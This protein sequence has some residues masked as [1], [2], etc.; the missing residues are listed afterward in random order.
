MVSIAEYFYLLLLQVKTNDGTGD[1]PVTSSY[2]QMSNGCIQGSYVDMPVRRNVTKIFVEL[3]RDGSYVGLSELEIFVEGKEI[4]E[5][6]VC[7]VLIKGVTEQKI[8][9]C[10]E[11]CRWCTVKLGYYVHR[12]V[13]K[14][15]LYYKRGDR[16][17]GAGSIVMTGLN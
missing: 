1:V 12:R 4:W 11:R 7:H 17:N 15:W 9:R 8:R 3:N 5:R 6:L 16:I 13:L 2:V 14:I 10:H